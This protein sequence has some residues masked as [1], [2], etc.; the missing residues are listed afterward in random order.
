MT[1]LKN[2]FDSLGFAYDFDK[3]MGLLR[4]SKTY[5]GKHPSTTLRDTKFFGEQ[6]ILKTMGFGGSNFEKFSKFQKVEI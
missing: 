6:H 1:S 4:L 2:I 3:I 5:S